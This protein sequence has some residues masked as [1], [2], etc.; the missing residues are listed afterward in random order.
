MHAWVDMEDKRASQDKERKSGDSRRYCR[1]YVFTVKKAP[2]VRREKKSGKK[3]AEACTFDY[4][5]SRRL[6]QGIYGPT[7]SF[8]IHALQPKPFEKWAIAEGVIR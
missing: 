3:P 6:G 7:T 1:K 2:A 5:C 8:S 4:S